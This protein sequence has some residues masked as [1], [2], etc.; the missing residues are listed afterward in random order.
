MRLRLTNASLAPRSLRIPAAAGTYCMLTI[1]GI[2]ALAGT[3]ANALRCCDER[4]GLM[5]PATKGVNEYGVYRRAASLAVCFAQL[6]ALIDQMAAL[7][8][9]MPR[10]EKVHT[11]KR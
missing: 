2:A 11:A 3:T 10:T 7:S 6:R 8:R 4:K 1:G 9:R 5:H